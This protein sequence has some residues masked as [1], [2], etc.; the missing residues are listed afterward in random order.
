MKR[1]T[2]RSSQNGINNQFCLYESRS[3]YE[4][5]RCILG[6]PNFAHRTVND[7]L[8][9]SELY[10][11]L[12]PKH[13]STMNA[14]DPFA[15]PTSFLNYYGQEDQLFQRPLLH[16]LGQN[17]LPN[18]RPPLQLPTN[19]FIEYEKTRQPV[20]ENQET[21]FTDHDSKRQGRFFI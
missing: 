3:S 17:Y 20:Q 18:T 12:E 11:T 6:L 9:E 5:I 14:A 1:K 21:F 2:K 4:R 16:T 13:Q 19:P 10:N 7:A 8:F 15:P